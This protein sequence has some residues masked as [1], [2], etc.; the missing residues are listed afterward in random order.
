[1]STITAAQVNELRKRTGAGMMDCKN[2]LTEANGDQELAIEILRKKGQKIASK[3]A[4]K[5]A[6]EGIVLAKSNQKENYGV[7]IMLNCETD[8]VAKNEEFVSFATKILDLAVSN[9]AK[10]LDTLKSLK[11][12]GISVEESVSEMMGK[13]GERMELTLEFLEGPKV[14][15]YNH[16]GNRLSTMAAFNSDV[17]TENAKQV[18]MQIAA[19]SPIAVDKDDVP[20]E[21]IEKEIEIGKEQ[22]RGEGK[23]EAMLEK[24]ALGKL[25]KFYNENTLLNQEF[26][27]DNKKT[28]RQFLTELNKDLTVTAFKRVQLGN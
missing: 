9:E 6:S 27:R 14:A 3:R 18:A 20:K 22:A 2:A 1:M 21:I 13:T 5:N 10:S 25:N 12:N 17:D 16:M 11:L 19:M 8:F 7:I 26:V 15:V 4:D 28:I 24:I 23:P